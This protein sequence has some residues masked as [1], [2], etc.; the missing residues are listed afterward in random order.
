MNKFCVYFDRVK[1]YLFSSLVFVFNKSI[2][3]NEESEIEKLRTTIENI[4][5][6]VKDLK[7]S[8][9]NFFNTYPTLNLSDNNYKE[10]YPKDWTSYPIKEIIPQEQERMYDSDEP[11]ENSLENILKITQLDNNTKAEFTSIEEEKDD[12]IENNKL[13]DLVNDYKLV[14]I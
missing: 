7:K 1:E 8:L 13:L 14:N 3:E 9:H 11:P 12:T 6:E 4:K 5:D 2:K 10:Y